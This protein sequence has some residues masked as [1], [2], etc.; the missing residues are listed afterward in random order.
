VN[1][2][3]PWQVNAH[4]LSGGAMETVVDGVMYRILDCYNVTIFADKG[5]YIGIHEGFSPNNRVFRVDELTGE[6]KAN[7]EYD[8]I[9][10]LFSL[11][12]DK[13]LADPAKAQAIL[14]ELTPGE[15]ELSAAEA[16]LEDAGAAAYTWEE[17]GSDTNI[18]FQ[19]GDAAISN[20]GIPMG[21]WLKAVP[22]D[23]TVKELSV[24]KDGYINYSYSYE[25]GE[26]TIREKW[27]MESDIYFSLK[28]RAEEGDRRDYTFNERR[29][30]TPDG[31][32]W[33][34]VRFTIDE[35]GVLTGAIILLAV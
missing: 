8:G 7:P 22:V 28:H 25:Y 27:S 12:L 15:A 35:N 20:N 34:A 23:S 26:G 18:Y 19:A 17:A 31:T 10:A 9:S 2:Q 1:G 6:I 29:I 24:D 32:V 11:P 3:Q 4:T 13:S 30:E 21:G 33:E 14:D 5:V 16:P